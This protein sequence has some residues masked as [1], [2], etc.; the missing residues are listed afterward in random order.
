MAITYDVATD[1]GNEPGVTSTWAHTV[2]GTDVVLLVGVMRAAVQT[3]SGVTYNGVALTQIGAAHLTNANNYGLSFW[4]LIG[5]ATGTH[6][7]V[8]TMNASTTDLY[9]LSASYAGVSQTGFPDASLYGLRTS[10]GSAVTESLTTTADNDWLVWFGLDEFHTGPTAGTG[11]TLRI[12][13]SAYGGI[14][15]ADSNGPKTP[16]GSHSLQMVPGGNDFLN[17]FVV[18]LAPAS[19]ATNYTLSAAGGS[20]AITGSAAT[21]TASNATSFTLVAAGGS[22]AITGS[23]A[24][25]LQTVFGTPGSY[26][27]TGS[28]ATLTLSARKIAAASGSFL[29]T[30]RPATLR[31]SGDVSATDVITANQTTYLFLLGG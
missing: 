15:I 12:K 19:G 30:G 5:P 18:A 20:F 9:T 3:V 16:A 24:V 2:T 7:V 25:L 10:G 11:T 1:G 13:N 26:L 29:I 28:A 14:F 23:P 17:D 21:L 27:I 22:F 4:G 8:V 31:A 6:D